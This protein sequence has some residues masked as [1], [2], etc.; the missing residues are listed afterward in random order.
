MP[1]L[2]DI[3]KKSEEFLRKKG[4]GNARFNAECIMTKVLSCRR[5]DLYLSYAAQL[6]EEQ[7]SGIRVLLTRRSNR[8]PLQYI[9]GKWPFYGVELNVDGRALIPRQETEELVELLC[10]RFSKRRYDDLGI[11]DLGTGS[12]AI[13]ISLGKYFRRARVYASDFSQDALS[14]ARENAALNLIRNVTFLQSDWYSSISGTFDIIVSNPPYLAESE[15]EQ[16]QPEIKLFEPKSAIV[17]END[18]KADL[19]EIINQ[20]AKFLKPNGI[21]AL[22]TGESQHRDLSKLALE[23]FQVV[24]SVRD[25][26]AHDRFLFLSKQR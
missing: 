26:T 10:E 2:I 21:L 17:S 25:I 5:I 13:A 14:L 16:I 19:I 12:G 20:S 1:A 18:G 11:L 6:N 22:E 4:I 15:W 23:N 7:L 8:E 9:V 24:E 3:L